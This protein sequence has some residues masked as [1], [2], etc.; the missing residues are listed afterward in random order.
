MEA[1]TSYYIYNYSVQ[2]EFLFRNEDDIEVFINKLEE[3]LSSV[4]AIKKLLVNEFSFHALISFYNLEVLKS[5]NTMPKFNSTKLLSRKL[6]NCFNAY[7]QSYN[8]NY[9][10]KGNLFR[11]S[12]KHIE[13]IEEDEFDELL[14]SSVT[15]NN[16]KVIFQ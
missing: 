3:H 4:A 12:L 14:E 10:R 6:S 11:K 13:L 16:L 5:Q 8:A 15:E 9:S 2:P 1:N 7:A